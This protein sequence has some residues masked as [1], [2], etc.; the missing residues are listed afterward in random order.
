MADLVV[1]KTTAILV[2]IQSPTL[3]ENMLRLESITNEYERNKLIP[4]AKKIKRAGGTLYVVGG[5]IRNHILGKQ[6]KDL[7]LVVVGLDESTLTN[8]LDEY[9]KVGKDFPVFLWDNYEVA[10][11][12]IETS[13]G[14]GHKDYEVSFGP[15]VTLEED[16]MRR[17]FTINTFYL[18]IAQNEFVNPIERALDDY[19]NGLLHP[20]GEHFKDDPLRVFRAGRF[21][22]EYPSL[23][24]SIELQEMC[25]EMSFD[26]M[27]KELP[28]ERVFEE[29]N[30]AFRG[31]E[32]N[33]YFKFLHSTDS[34]SFWFPEISRMIRVKDRHNETVWNHI[35]D[36]LS[37]FVHP[38]T[39]WCVLVHDIGKIVTDPKDYPS[40]YGHED[41]RGIAE[42]FLDRFKPPNA[43]NKI[44]LSCQKYHMKAHLIEEL[45]PGTI[46]DMFEDMNNVII[47]F[48]LELHM[49]DARSGGREHH[50]QKIGEL[51]GLY[52]MV[53]DEIDGHDVMEK[54]PDAKGERIGELLRQWRI[55]EFKKYVNRSG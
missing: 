13:T 12:R 38:I 53:C 42:K 32:P 21:L 18:D 14:K 55:N 31:I 8:I 15:E 47:H 19:H 23:S 28:A 43:V 37:D 34:L 5:A 29:T 25:I 48:F 1:S 27:L 30:K 6:Q 17:D 20:V 22:A 35:M 9:K 40:H 2:R 44:A 26:N 49:L 41:K 50:S 46:F 7:D 16:A 51:Y 3:G 11:A 45:R 33:R 24:P 54:H 4:L 36:M 39:G 52:E 10:M